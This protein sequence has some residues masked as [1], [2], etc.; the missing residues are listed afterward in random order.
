MATSKPAETNEII[1]VQFGL[2][3]GK[4]G[5]AHDNSE[6][7]KVPYDFFRQFSATSEA[8]SW[9]IKK[10]KWK[11]RCETIVFNSLP[12]SKQPIPR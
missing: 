3:Q 2:R 10:R 12:L 11:R 5:K 1:K 6:V 9:T 8:K 7:K 4:Q